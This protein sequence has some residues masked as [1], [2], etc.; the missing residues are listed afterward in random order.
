MVKQEK[1]AVIGL[2]YVGLPLLIELSKHHKVIGYD[3]DNCRIEGLKAGEDT[4]REVTEQ[5]LRGCITAGALFTNKVTDIEPAT[6]YIC[7]VPTPVDEHN[8]PN[9]DMLINATT[10]IGKKLSAGNLVIYESTVFPGATEEI[11]IPIL[12]EFSSLKYNEGFSCGYSPERINPGDNGRK[13]P[14]IIKVVSA[15]SKASLDRVR[16]IYEKIV[17]AGV[18]EAPSIVVAEAA[19]VIENTQRDVNVALVN[20]FALIFD[21]LNIDTKSV[22]EAAL[23][24][25]NFL[26]FQPGLVGGHCISIDPYYLAHKAQEVGYK[27]DLIMSAR[28]INDNMGTHIAHKFVKM[29]LSKGALQFSKR[30]LVMGLTFKEDCPDL[31]NTGVISI[32]RELETYG[33]TVDVHDPVCNIDEAQKNYGI[34]IVKLSNE[35]SYAGVIITVAH[36]EFKKMSKRQLKQLGINNA[37]ILDVK[38]IFPPDFSDYRL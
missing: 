28:R 38:S 18:Y 35:D 21:K 29:L 1:I 15:G 7:T 33:L 30:V 19:K 13:L 14:D 2:G 12:E 37:V 11:C 32:I 5:A 9:L 17:T 8:S 23:T 34:N 10:A 27:P 20:E 26:N 25:W 3:I 16:N 24:K 4:T 31:R 22:L 36:A 6:V